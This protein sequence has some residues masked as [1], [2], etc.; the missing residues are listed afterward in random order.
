M[1]E[2]KGCQMMNKTA[3]QKPYV[4]ENLQAADFHETAASDDVISMHLF[5]DCSISGEDID[6]LC[7]E[8]TVFRNVV[9]IDVSFRF[10][11][12]TDVIFEKCDVSNADFS[13]AVLHRTLFKQSKMVGMNLAD[14][15]LRNVSFEECH[16]QFSS[17]YYSNMKH[18]LFHHCVLLQSECSSM[19]LQQTH[20]DACELEGANFT[21]TSLQNVDISS[22]RFEQIH[23]SLD[24]LKG[25]K[26]A[27]EHAMAFARAL[28][29]VIV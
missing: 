14:S 23:V 1:Q 17:F 10:I 4:P 18:V 12:L 21:G 22:C 29:A 27:P 28:G 11:E 6:R 8:K 5:E 2:C 20:F 7:I 24:K 9:F 16:G 26:I 13:G 3:I 19:A 15:T 25:C